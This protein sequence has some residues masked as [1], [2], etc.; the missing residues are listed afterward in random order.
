MNIPAH[1]TRLL[2]LQAALGDLEQDRLDRTE[3]ACRQLLAIQADD[4]QAT[5]LLGLALG[6]Q[7][8]A[9]RAA[10]FL[11]RAA[12]DRGAQA[13]PAHD[14][15]EI[16]RRTGQEEAITAQY[17]A[18]LRLAPGDV[19]L[20][21]GF[22]GHLLATDQPAEAEPVLARAL[23]LA[24]ELSE[25]HMLMGSAQHELGRMDKAIL[26]FRRA[27]ESAPQAAAGWANLGMVLKIEGQFDE[28]IA[29]YDRAVALAPHEPQ[30][31]VNRAVALD[32]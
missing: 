9:D 2:L 10:P 6:G 7:A 21:L 11:H 12:R 22:A 30:I 8:R 31:R 17:R 24:P 26:H 15:A 16:L 13:H 32:G 23:R 3:A 1:P 20:R 19:D 28:A 27:T 29:A 4:M 5:L 14:V 25:A 18:C